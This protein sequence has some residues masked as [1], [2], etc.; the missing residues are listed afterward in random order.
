MGCTA[1]TPT[2]WG[3]TVVL[4]FMIIP[5]DLVRKAIIKIKRK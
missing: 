2:Q 1:M 4:A 3:V 5:I